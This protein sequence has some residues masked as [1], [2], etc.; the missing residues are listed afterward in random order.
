MKKQL[1]IGG[2]WVWGAIL[3][4]LSGLPAC[5]CEDQPFIAPDKA[6][7]PFQV[8]DLYW[9]DLG[10]Y[11]QFNRTV[12]STSVIPG[13]TLIVEGEDQHFSGYF[14][15]PEPDLILLY[16]CDIY[17]LENCGI[18]VRLVSES[19]DRAVRSVSGKLLDGDAD[20]LQF[21][22]FVREM[23]PVSGCSDVQAPDLVEPLILFDTIGIN[24]ITLNNDLTLTLNFEFS[25]EPVRLSSVVQGETFFIEDLNDNQAPVGGTLEWLNDGYLLYFTSD[26]P[27]TDYCSDLDPGCRVLWRIRLISDPLAGVAIR[28]QNAVPLDGDDDFIPGGT[29]VGYLLLN[30]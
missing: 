10:V 26:L 6:P 19:L 1:D 13:E 2:N 25:F 11:I 7:D 8:T 20:G 30:L 23:V 12:D 4:L 18:T 9:G 17:C 5:N 27:Y 16:R 28:G 3:V 22:D 15:L 14:E 29:Y 24:D 21:G